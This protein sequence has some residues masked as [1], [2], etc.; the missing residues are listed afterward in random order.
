MLALIGLLAVSPASLRSS[1]AEA[2]QAAPQ[3]ITYTKLTGNYSF[4]APG[5]ENWN[6]GQGTLTFNSKGGVSGV[7]NYFDDS[8]L[9]VGMLL[10]GTYTVNPGLATGSA[11]MVLSS[12]STNN[13]ALLGDSDTMSLQ[14]SIGASGNIITF[15]EMDPYED[16]YFA[17]TFYAFGGTATHY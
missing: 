15:A 2:A 14:L 11:Q 9:C 7:L 5:Y 16:G 10:N 12:V 3:A 8:V 17:D 4:L 1:G 6:Y 13:C